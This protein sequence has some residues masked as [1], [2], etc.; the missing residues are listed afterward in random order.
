MRSALQVLFEAIEKDKAQ[1]EFITD[2]SFVY[3]GIEIQY[4]GRYYGYASRPG[5][6]EE[7]E[8]AGD[9]YDSMLDCVIPFTGKSIRVMMEELDEKDLQLN[10]Y[11][12]G[13][14]KDPEEGTA[15]GGGDA[16]PVHP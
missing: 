11:V 5:K 3:D 14:Y 1:T 16:K 9:D 10:V 4:Y 15:G 6:T 12:M 2:F 13:S 7:Y 8:F